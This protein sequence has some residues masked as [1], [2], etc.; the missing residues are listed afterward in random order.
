LEYDHY[1]GFAERYD[2]FFDY[3][4][5]LDSLR[6]DFYRKLF[7]DNKVRS[8]L[9]CACGTGRD[10]LLFYSLGLDVSGSDISE[11]MLNQA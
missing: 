3:N 1:E 5:D 4:P 11:S 9:D 10:L 7:D 2:L 8:I 6:S